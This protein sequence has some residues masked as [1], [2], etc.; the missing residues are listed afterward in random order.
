MSELIEVELPDGQIIWAR[1]EDNGGP[2]D[3]GLHDRIQKL[4]GLTEA[5]QGVAGNVRD[6]M[7]TV[8]PDEVS[9]EFGI[10][11]TVGEDGLVAALAGVSGTATLDVT[12]SW[13]G[14]PTT[15]SSA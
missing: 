6:A 3:V 14:G 9:V 5:L 2:Q 13:S 12:L 11:L 8:K 7:R 10:E 4:K 1:V 15:K